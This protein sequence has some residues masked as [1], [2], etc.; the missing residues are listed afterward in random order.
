MTPFQLGLGSGQA[1]AFGRDGEHDTLSALFGD[2]EGENVIEDLIE[3]SLVRS[4]ADDRQHTVRPL[5]GL[6]C[7]D[8]GRK[9]RKR[10]AVGSQDIVDIA[11]VKTD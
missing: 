7:C 8:I 4:I 3:I 10:L 5:I 2:M 9:R 11:S 6:V 1:M